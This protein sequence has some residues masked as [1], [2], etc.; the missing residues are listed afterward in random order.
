MAVGEKKKIKAELKLYPLKE[1]TKEA[2]DFIGKSKDLSKVYGPILFSRDMMLDPRKWTKKS[3]SDAMA[4]Y[5]RYEMKI[6]CVRVGE[7]AKAE[8][9]GKAAKDPKKT[10]KELSKSYEDMKKEIFNKV[11]LGLD[12]VEADKGDNA[13]N[14]KDCKAAFGKLDKVDFD[15]MY[16]GPRESVLETLE[17][18]VEELADESD[19]P[20]EKYKAKFLSQCADYVSESVKAFK[21]N[22]KEATDAVD[23]LLKAAKTT[24]AN[25]GAAPELIAYAETVLKQEGK[26]NSVLAKSKSFSSALETA[27][28]LLKGGKV[29][30]N[31]AKLQVVIFKKLSKLD[32]SAKDTLAACKKLR[33]EFKKIEKLLK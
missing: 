8:K 22:G 20:D 10:E 24:K 5:V 4:A 17:N 29:T 2:R 33:P 13:K 1:M 11:S 12:E 6:L 21:E 16:K 14:L 18:L 23:T 31:Q 26:I 28:K 19:E 25:K 32:T 7:A 27:E 3:L 9:A 15:W 30:E